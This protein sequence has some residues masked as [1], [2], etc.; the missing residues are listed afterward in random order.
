MAPSPYQRIGSHQLPHVTRT[1]A[2]IINIFNHC[3]TSFSDIHT[4]TLVNPRALHKAIRY[5]LL[6]ET[7]QAAS[8]EPDYTIG[9][10]FTENLTF[11]KHCGREIT[12][13]IEGIL[14]NAHLITFLKSHHIRSR[15]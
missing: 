6:R 15:L 10:R 1:D 7:M 9:S 8:D 11:L 3:L 14:T 2:K 13:N 5:F 12:P 4:Q